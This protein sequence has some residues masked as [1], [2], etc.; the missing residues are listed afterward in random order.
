M[1]IG[2][3][4]AA[5]NPHHPSGSFCSLQVL[6]ISAFL[7]AWR[8]EVPQAQPS[9]NPDQGETFQKAMRVFYQYAL[10]Q[11]GAKHKHA[12]KKLPN[13]WGFSGHSEAS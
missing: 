5:A 2:W 11:K 10:K 7:V 3:H 4:A 8:N 9:Q 1:Q 12:N 6:S 13:L